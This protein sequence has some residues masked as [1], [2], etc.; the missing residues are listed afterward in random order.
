MPYRS[1]PEVRGR[2]AARARPVALWRAVSLSL[3]IS[4]AVWLAI[5]L[6]LTGSANATTVF[7][8][9]DDEGRTHYGEQVPDRYRATA[10]P[11][12]VDS[13]GP[14]PEQQRE[15]AERARDLQQRADALR[16]ARNAAAASAPARAA[17]APPAKRPPQPPAADT[18]CATWQRLYEESLACFAPF[19]TTHGSTR[20][21]AFD[22]CT[23]VDEPPAERC[24]MQ[25]R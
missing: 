23:P 3:A 4:W 20:P 7:R 22:V 24:R 2:P 8:W 25:V 9:V 12:G 17:S 5:S 6:G 19:R 14:T 10:R 11:V 13:A 18:D 21:E 16:S 1:T 15:A